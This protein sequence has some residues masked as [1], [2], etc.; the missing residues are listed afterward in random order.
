M[1]V[2]AFAAFRNLADVGDTWVALASGRH[3]ARCGVHCADPFSFNSLPQGPTSDEIRTWPRCL[4]RIV[5]KVGIASVRYW[6]PAGWINQNWL[7]HLLFYRLATHCGT[8]EDPSYTSL[9]FLKFIFYLLTVLCVYSLTRLLGA[10]PASASWCSCFSMLVGVSFTGLRPNEFSNLLTPVFVMILV[11]TTYRHVLYAWL[12]VPLGV[13][14]GNLHGGY[15]YM[16]LMMVPFVFMHMLIAL[17]RRWTPWC[18]CA[19]AWFLL[20]AL[21]WRNGYQGTVLPVATADRVLAALILMAVLLGVVC[22]LLAAQLGTICSYHGSVSALLFLTAYAKTLT[23]GGRTSAALILVFLAFLLLG[24]LVTRLKPALISVKP[25]ASLHLVAAS[26]VTLGL[27]ILL[28]PFH[29]ANVTHLWVISWGEHAALWRNIRE[30]RPVLDW[31]CRCGFVVPFLVMVGGFCL[32]LVSWVSVQC[33]SA[34]RQGRKAGEDREPWFPRCHLDVALLLVALLTVYMAMCSR[35]FIPIAAFVC[36]PLLAVW[37]GQTISPLSRVM[38]GGVENPGKRTVSAKTLL[39]DLTLWATI[40][41]ICLDLMNGY[42]CVKRLIAPWPDGFQNYS[43]FERLVS[44]HRQ[45]Q[46]ACDFLKQNHVKGRMLN[47]WIEGGFIAWRMD[48]QPKTGELELR[49]FI[50]GRAQTAYGR[51][52]TGIGSIYGA[53][54]PSGTR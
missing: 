5:E 36:C 42:F 51:S 27:I 44:I 11:L 10:H 3:I 17:P 39:W 52:R 41:V 30:W 14:W 25:A 43:V 15:V 28:S 37:I 48:P 22:T 33:W 31:T 8:E 9:L 34:L 29:I 12:L 21:L 16:F 38:T 4:Q 53:V 24:V 23:E 46:G 49:L 7:S 6:H 1:F 47:D 40:F 35:R 2:F 19:S 32:V 54:S 20:Y 45:P 18:Y 13:L 50:D 26:M